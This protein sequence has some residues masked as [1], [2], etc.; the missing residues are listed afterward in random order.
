MNEELW[1]GECETL[2]RGFP[3]E[4]AEKVTSLVKHSASEAKAK[5]LTAA[6]EALETVRQILIKRNHFRRY[7]NDIWV[8]TAIIRSIRSQSS[9]EP[10]PRAFQR[11]MDSK[12]SLKLDEDLSRDQKDFWYG[13]PDAPVGGEIRIVSK[14]GSDAS[15]AKKGCFIATAAYGSDLAPEVEIL[16]AFLPNPVGRR[17]VQ[18]YNKI[19]PRLASWVEPRPFVRMIVRMLILSPILVILNAVPP[20]G[21]RRGKR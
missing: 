12:P 7:D 15:G 5:N 20:R 3:D 13:S 4:L 14:D 8:F 2:V 6:A 18:W 17:F 16:R 9:E 21:F 11:F 1:I 19:S 10:V